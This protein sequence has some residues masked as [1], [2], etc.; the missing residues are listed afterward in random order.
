MI[1][2]LLALLVLAF[3]PAASGSV[4]RCGS[5]G[6]VTKNVSFAILEDYDK[7][8]DLDDVAEDFKLMN[9]L[10]IDVLRC[11]FGWD[12]YEPARG[13]YDFAWLKQFVTLADRYGIKLRPYIGYTPEWAGVAGSDEM[14]WNDPPADYQD[15]Y[16]FVYHLAS[17]LR[18]YPNVL[19]YEI[20]N[21]ENDLFWWEG[22]FD[23]YSETLRQGSRA[24][25]A[26]NPKAQVILGGMVFPDDDWLVSLL[27]VG[28]AR[29]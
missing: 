12:D 11:S 8:Q 1:A 26:A 5:T 2:I 17:V 14:V 25:H 27:E 4:A 15:W 28:G 20:Y 23:T 29:Y 19:S 24:I 21:E 13:Q 22:G 9:Q 10:G 18:S 7:G 3:S 16:N 6:M